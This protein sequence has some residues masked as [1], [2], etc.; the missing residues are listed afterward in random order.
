MSVGNEVSTTER[1][2][3]TAD[4]RQQRIEITGDGPSR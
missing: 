3:E 2:E 1:R 4:N